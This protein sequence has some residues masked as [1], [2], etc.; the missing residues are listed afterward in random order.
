M[1]R[2]LPG[3]F[4]KAAFDVISK[5]TARTQAPTVVTT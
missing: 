5:P 2:T 1:A 4:T 3:N